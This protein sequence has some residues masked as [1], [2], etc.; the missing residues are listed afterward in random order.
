MKH[1][2]LV[3]LVTPFN[4]D[5]SVNKE[6][7]VKL[8]DLLIEEGADG[9]YAL[10]SSAECFLLTEE[11]RKEVLELIVKSA[12]G[13]Y[14]IAHIGDGSTKKAIMF[15]KHAESLGVD[16]VS[17]V[18][19]FYFQYS[20][21][22]I[23]GY[24]KAISESVSIPLIIYNAP[25][26]MKQ[27]F[28]LDQMID[29]LSIDNISGMKF[30][31]SNFYLLEQ[32]RSATKKLVYSGSDEVYLASLIMGS[33]GVIGTSLNI[34]LESFI[35]IYQLFQDKKYDQALQIQNQVNNVIRVL[36]DVGLIEGLKYVLSLEG[37]KA[38]HSRKP[39]KDLKEQDK[40]KLEKVWKQ[41]KEMV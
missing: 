25:S 27:K 39:F 8:I 4:E 40:I 22:E 2:F 16:A 30:T 20:F 7:L 33:T 6:A 23:K 29:L 36:I 41:Y 11:E 38:G 9:F 32:V 13:K 28:T 14:I 37:V 31:D 3:P 26:Y 1:Q 21:E 24:Y 35:K 15:A 5:E 19:P 18:A 17:S 10:G 34:M 12:K